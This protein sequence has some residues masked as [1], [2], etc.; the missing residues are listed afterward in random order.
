MARRKNKH[1]KKRTY[2]QTS[3]KNQEQERPSHI[4]IFEALGVGGL[5]IL[6]YMLQ[7]SHKL[8]ATWV[9]F[10]AWVAVGLIVAIRL[11]QEYSADSKH[12]TATSPPNELDN[13]AAQTVTPKQSPFSERPSRFTEGVAAPSSTPEQSPSPPIN[14]PATALTP[15]Q[16]VKE[17]RAARPFQRREIAKTFVGI[18]VDWLLIFLNANRLPDRLSEKEERWQLLF[19]PKDHNSDNDNRDIIVEVEIPIKGNEYL[20]GIDKGEMFRVKGVI[21]EI[22]AQMSS[23]FLDNISLERDLKP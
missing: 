11:T 3:L 16:I 15:L 12:V 20:R 4:A 6:G 9:F 17:V 2:G 18:P 5:L 1:R 8:A 22:D 10:A 13:R 23:I 19:R 7:P 14:P 21:K